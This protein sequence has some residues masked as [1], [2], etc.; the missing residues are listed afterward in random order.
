M[1]DRDSFS[2]V[3]FVRG[4]SGA[5]PGR[6][7]ASQILFTLFLATVVS[8]MDRGIIA[9]LI[10]DLKATFGLSDTEISIVQGMAFSVFF[11]LASIPV[12][13]LVDRMNRRNLIIAGILFWSGATMACG[14]AETYPQLLIAR[15]C[16]GVGEASLI[17][18]AYS[19]VADCFVSERRGRAMS[20]LVAAASLGGALSN[21]VG[22]LL[23][24]AV[25][26]SSHV[27]VP[28]LG[29]LLVW[30]FVFVVFGSFGV[31]L[32]ALLLAFREPQRQSG[33]SYVAAS[34]KS[35]PSFLSFARRDPYLYGATFIIVALIFTTTTVTSIWIV[36]ALTRVHHVDTATSG[37]LIGFTKLGS[38]VLGSLVGGAIGDMLSQTNGRYGRFNIWIM[39]MPLLALG[40][41]LL[42][43]PGTETAFVVGFWLIGIAGAAIAGASYPIIYDIVPAELRGQSVAYC[44]TIANLV[45]FGIGPT[46]PAL[47]NDRAFKDEAMIH[48]SLMI[49]TVGASLVAWIMIFSIRRRFE[50]ART[51]LGDS[52]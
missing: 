40:G 6:A 2:S 30:R 32:T 18:A 22:G 21:L 26:G 50:R 5:Y 20:L 52:A 49:V 1:A 46:L 24:K 23:L 12:G 44:M 25:S 34:A 29:E 38:H 45:S 4:E 3:S 47:L 17:P 33:R 10:P 37:M 27:V 11:S 35:G 8:Y 41:L 16:V 36:V 9:L 39:G 43:W 7:V 19:I 14:L 15:A 48:W 28:L 51:I 13:H 31:V 42:V